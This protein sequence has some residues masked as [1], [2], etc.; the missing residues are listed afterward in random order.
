MKFDSM[1]EFTAMGPAHFGCWGY[2]RSWLKLGLLIY[3][4]P[5]LRHVA[6]LW[7]PS[8]L[9]RILTV[10]SNW[11]IPQVN[12]KCVSHNLKFQVLE[13][14]LQCKSHRRYILR[15]KDQ[16]NNSLFLN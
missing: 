12:S 1:I 10:G 4:A 2:S 5:T 11:G 14:K 8:T 13:L 15:L 6:L 7:P 3:V 9:L 16:E